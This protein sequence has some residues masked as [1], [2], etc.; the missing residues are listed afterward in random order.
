MLP[1]GASHPGASARNDNGVAF[2]AFREHRFL[3]RRVEK[4]RPPPFGAQDKR[5]AAATPR[6][7]AD[8]QALSRVYR[9]RRPLEANGKPFA[10][11]GRQECLCY[12]EEFAALDRCL[13]A[14][15]GSSTAAC[16]IFRVRFEAA[17][18]DRETNSPS[19]THFVPVIRGSR[20]TRTR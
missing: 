20:E 14:G 11:Q 10:P 13:P 7:T 15:T 5:S 18:D 8:R 9:A 4:R 19:K 3:W 12:L 1:P 17:T 2:A 6:Q 16:A